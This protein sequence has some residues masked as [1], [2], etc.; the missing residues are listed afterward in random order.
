VPRCR[1]RPFDIPFDIPLADC[2]AGWHRYCPSLRRVH[3]GAMLGIAWRRR[4][5]GDV[6]RKVW[7]EDV[8]E[9]EDSEESDFGWGDGGDDVD[10]GEIWSEVGNQSV[11]MI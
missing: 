5:D 6:W 2:L 1:G 4:W 7:V 9:P 11:R 8:E 3:V 10:E